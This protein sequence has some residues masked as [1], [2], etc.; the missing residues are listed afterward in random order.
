MVFR[1]ILLSA[2]V[3]LG[4][5]EGEKEGGGGIKLRVVLQR[6]RKFPTFKNLME[7]FAKNF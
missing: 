4:L 6:S 7:N 5:N 3:D 2:S 1:R